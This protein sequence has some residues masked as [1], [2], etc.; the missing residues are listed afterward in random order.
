MKEV[1]LTD[2][3]DFPVT[4]ETCQAY[5]PKLFLNHLGIMTRL[6]K[7]PLASA[8]AGAKATAIQWFSAKL[9]ARALQ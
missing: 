4:E 9:T 1:F 7:Q 8:V 6:P 2:R 5:R 3:A